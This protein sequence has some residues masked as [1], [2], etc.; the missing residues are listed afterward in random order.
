M[1]HSDFSGDISS[2]DFSDIDEHHEHELTS[3]EYCDWIVAFK[4]S[5]TVEVL[6]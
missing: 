6:P 4:I 3:K 1:E 5:G 2:D